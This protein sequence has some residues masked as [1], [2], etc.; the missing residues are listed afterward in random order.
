M[1]R[2]EA[3][4]SQHFS[5]LEYRQPNEK[6]LE[7]QMGACFL[8]APDQG[9]VYAT[10]PLSIALCGLGPILD[11]YSVVATRD[12]TMSCADA[13][14]MNS[15]FTVFAESVRATLMLRY[16]SCLMTEHGR[17]PVCTRP[18][19]TEEHC[20]H[21]HFLL[22]PAAP[23]ITKSAQSHF[24]FTQTSSSLDDALAIARDQSEYFLLSP[25]PKEYFIMT[26]PISLMRQFARY[27]V[28]EAIGC[29]EKADWSTYPDRPKAEADAADLAQIVSAPI[30][31][32]WM[33]RK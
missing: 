5:V 4:K 6:E 28:A 7:S 24:A 26:S 1:I 19:G 14:L 21:G 29:P 27:M 30:R 32:P 33:Q 8:C 22:F 16:G 23:D 20:F 25:S 17:L 9:L 13:A 10:A 18:T 15:E 2:W 11:G 31:I 3:H 12:H